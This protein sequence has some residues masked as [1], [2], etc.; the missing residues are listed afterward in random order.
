M[1]GWFCN[2]YPNTFS[3]IGGQSQLSRTMMG[4]V[5]DQASCRRTLR[6]FFFRRRSNRAA[7]APGRVSDRAPG[8]RRA[9][10]LQARE[11]RVP[12]IISD[13]TGKY[14]WGNCIWHRCV[15]DMPPDED[16]PQLRV[17]PV[18]VPGD[19][20]KSSRFFRFIRSSQH[21]ECRCR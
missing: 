14:R 1:N 2:L 13:K 7:G 10:T 15:R 5:A 20:G 18:R 16:T 12:V 4:L 21:I 19:K 9:Y 6:F 3:I 17:V 11:N 8:L